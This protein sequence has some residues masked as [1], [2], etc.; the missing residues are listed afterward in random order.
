MLTVM[1][2]MNLMNLVRKNTCF[3]IDILKENV[4]GKFDTKEV[5]NYYLTNY[6]KRK[7]DL[8][9]NAQARYLAVFNILLYDMKMRFLPLSKEEKEELYIIFEEAR[10][11]ENLDCE[12]NINRS[13][14]FLEKIK[15]MDKEEEIPK[16]NLNVVPLKTPVIKKEHKE[17]VTHPSLEDE[18]KRQLQALKKELEIQKRMNKEQEEKNLRLEEELQKEKHQNEV[19]KK[20]LDNKDYQIG[21]EKNVQKNL[22]EENKMWQ[23]KI[24][25]LEQ[26]LSKFSQLKKSYSTVTSYFQKSLNDEA[27]AREEILKH[28]ETIQNLR[29]DIADHNELKKSYQELSFKYKD[30]QSEEKRKQEELLKQKEFIQ[31]LEQKTH[32]E[33]WNE[34]L[35]EVHFKD[36]EANLLYKNLLTKVSL[37]DLQNKL[38]MEG[39]FYSLEDI[40]AF[41]EKMAK[42]YTLRIEKGFK[43]TYELQEA[44]FPTDQVFTLENHGVL[45]LIFVSDYH[46]RKIDK[47]QQNQIDN[48]YNYCHQNNIRTVINLGDFYSFWDKKPTFSEVENILDDTI[49]N[50]PKDDEIQQGILIGNHDRPFIGGKRTLDLM[51]TLS[52]ERS[53]LISLGWQ[54]AHLNIG[55]SFVGIHHVPRRFIYDKND[56]SQLYRYTKDYYESDNNVTHES[57]LDCFG[58]FHID[59]LSF[60]RNILSVPSFFKD[61]VQNGFYELDFYLNSLNQIETIIFKPFLVQNGNF[62]KKEEIYQPV[63]KRG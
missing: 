8:T 25:A 2:K 20:M 1:D 6:Q 53:D 43:P 40:R 4:K 30:S 56:L 59:C 35:Q 60:N 58:H 26:D 63:L 50:Y 18:Y 54:H 39:I 5:L 48:L 23:R 15:V 3:D 51:E 24:N 7:T 11:N 27:K 13:K 31:A 46:L 37:V 34:A 28:K 61:R 22:Q 19:H 36:D 32:E 21:L 44:N 12:G 52:K 33:N 14:E 10:Q 29:K 41:F 38:R 45:K 17:K 47:M 57:V 49:K 42:R 9:S 16:E 62:I 55:S